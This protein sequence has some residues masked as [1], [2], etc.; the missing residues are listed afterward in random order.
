MIASVIGLVPDG[1]VV[2]LPSYA[3]LE[4]VKTVW[5]AS[6][7]LARLATKKQVSPPSLAGDI[8]DDYS[9][10]TNPRLLVTLSRSSETIRSLSPPVMPRQQQTRYLQQRHLPQMG[11]R[12]EH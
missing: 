10:S 1:V 2:F 6:G 11:S 3:F 5:T 7:V 8:T 9:C 4:R 12:Q